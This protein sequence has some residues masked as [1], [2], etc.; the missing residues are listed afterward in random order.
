MA[1]AETRTRCGTYLSFGPLGAEHVH[2]Q[3]DAAIGLMLDDGD[4]AGE[5]GRDFAA[6]H[7]GAGPHRLQLGEQHA[8]GETEQCREA[9]D[10]G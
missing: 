4:A 5:P 1:R 8:E 6:H 3:A 7:L 9:P 2:R 10:G